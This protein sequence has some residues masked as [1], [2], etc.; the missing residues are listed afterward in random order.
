MVRLVK[1]AYWDTEIKRAQVD[2]LAGYPVFTRK[3]HTDVAYLACAKAMLAAPDAI[4]PQF[5]T[6]N[7]FTIA[8]IHTLAG[9]ARLR[10]PV[11]ARHGRE[12]LRPDRRRAAS[13]IA[14]CRIY[15]PVGSHETL[16]A[17]SRAAAARERRQHLVRQPHRRSGGQHR[18]DWSPI[19]SPRRRR[20]AARRIRRFRCR[21][22]CC[23]DGA[24]RRASTSP[25]TTLRL[26]RRW[27]RRSTRSPTV[28]DAARRSGRV[29]RA[30]DAIRNPADRGDVGGHGDRSDGRAM[31]SARS[32]RH[33]GGRAVVA[34]RRPAS[35]RRVP[36]ARRGLLESER[37][38]FI[39]L[40]VR[41]AGKT[42]RR[43][44]RRSARGGRLLPLL[45]GAATC[46]CARNE[47]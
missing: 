24:I 5:A 28:R 11:P 7:A 12:H 1:G 29:A 42:L 9:N 6:H 15:A 4:Y 10:V 44:G 27:R 2:G 16:L 37:A 46:S 26:R 23:R 35:A 25:T 40:A 36:R 3:V 20:P 47:P 31:R 18:V 17:V 45:R 8:A 21:R 14:P 22:R 39:A 41:E 43:C 33:R 32:H 30:P 13:S 19:R 38:T 34:T